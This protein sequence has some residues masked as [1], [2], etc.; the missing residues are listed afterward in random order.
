MF[1][2]GRKLEHFKNGEIEEESLK[3][4]HA[5]LLFAK[6]NNAR[7]Y[8]SEILTILRLILLSVLFQFQR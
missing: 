2:L 6:K 3:K 8:C 1:L 5:D 7:F 4:S